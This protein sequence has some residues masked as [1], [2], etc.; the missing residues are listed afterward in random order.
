MSVSMPY[1]EFLESYYEMAL[2]YAENTIR[3]VIKTHGHIHSAIDVDSVIAEG[4]LSGLE[5]TY[6][7]YSS[8][9]ESGAKVTTLLNR[10]VHNAVLTELEKATTAAIKADL[11]PP[12]PTKKKMTEEEK[13]K[14]LEQICRIIAGVDQRAS[15]AKPNESHTYQEA[16][17]WHERKEKEL[18]RIRECMTRLPIHDQV[19]L[20]HWAEDEKTYI[21]KSL[22]ELGLENTPKNANWAY[23]RRKRALMSLSHMMGGKK[24]EYRDIYFPSAKFQTNIAIHSCQKE[25][26]SIQFKSKDQISGNI[27]YTKTAQV[28]SEKVFN[29]I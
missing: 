16:E 26:F 10:I 28:I 11:M 7:K 17:G 15:P 13:E 3:S 2:K 21:E 25:P 1:N 18:Q 27:D 8:N 9:H 12:R 23:G 24:P 4:V 14:E 5:K 19:I 22:E 29:E 20:S 6:E